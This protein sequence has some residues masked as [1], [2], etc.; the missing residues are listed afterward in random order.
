MIIY[1]IQS[2]DRAW[3][4]FWREGRMNSLQDLTAAV[5]EGAVQRIRPKM[6]TVCAIIC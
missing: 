1:P 3:E 2:I 4:K 6:M 5:R